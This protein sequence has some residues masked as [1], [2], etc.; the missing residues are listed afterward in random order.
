M[1]FNAKLK[2]SN[3]SRNK[4]NYINVC[5]IYMCTYALTHTHTYIHTHAEL[6]N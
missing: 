6:E 5:C 2:N 3:I 4:Y 1:P